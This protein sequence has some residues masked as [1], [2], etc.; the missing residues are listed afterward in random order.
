[1]VTDTAVTKEDKLITS[2]SSFGELHQII[3]GKNVEEGLLKIV[4]LANNL[5]ISYSGYVPL[6]KEIARFI[7]DHYYSLSC[8]IPLLIERVIN[9]FGPFSD[10]KQVALLIGKYANDT[11]TAELYKWDSNKFDELAVGSD[12]MWTGSLSQTYAE[13]APKLLSEFVSGGMPPQ[14]VLP[15]IT[16]ILQSI[17]IRRS[18]LEMNVGGAFVGAFL[19]KTG[20]HWQE[21]ITYF[22]YNDVNKIKDFIKCFIIENALILQSTLSDNIK[23]LFDYVNDQSIMP[24]LD[25]WQKN[26]DQEVKSGT[27]RYYCFISNKEDNI[28]VIKSK[29]NTP[30]TERFEWIVSDDGRT[31]TW[32]MRSDLVEMLNNPV[33]R[34]K[35]DGSMP[36]SL[37]FLDYE[38]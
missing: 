33:V 2:L 37:R 13:I 26:V 19:D 1:M 32:R 4:P 34:D 15:I 12:C 14:R 3:N 17:G 30:Y 27:S 24:W 5:M 36:I 11:D 7:K 31:R 8:N 20:C 22:L 23:I 16:T 38:D 10:E 9:S 18:L 28:V 25:K 21:D 29:D 6:I 35:R